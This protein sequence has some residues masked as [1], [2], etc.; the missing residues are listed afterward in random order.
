MASQ[1]RK[2]S[3]LFI[4]ITI[5]VDVIGIGIIIP[6]VPELIMSINGGTE[7]EAAE[8][9]GWLMFSFAFMQFLFAP[10]LGELS[11][12]FGRKPILIMALFG[13]GLDYIFHAYAPT[14]FWLIIG[15][16][17]A[18]F[19]GA[20][21]TVA[22]SYM[23][24]ISTPED[25]AKNFGMIGAAFGLGFIIGPVVG[26]VAAQ[27]GVQMPFFIAACLSL[28][29]MLYGILVVPESLSIENRR[30]ISIKNFN[31]INAISNLR[32]YPLITGLILAYFLIYLAGK[33][34]ENIWSFYTMLRFDWT[35]AEVGYSL[36]FVGL[37]VVVVQGGLISKVV[38]KFGQFK[39]IIIGFVCWICGLLLF[40]FATEGWMMYA[41]CIVYCMGGVA[42]PTIQ[43][44]MSNMVPGNKQGE[45]AGALTSLIS[46]TSI[47][48]PLMFTNLFSVFTRNDA[49]FEFPG[50]SFF[51]G[52]I[53]AFIAMVF[54]VKTLRSN[55][56]KESTNTL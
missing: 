48:G 35:S 39:T 26:G 49:P 14:V 27:W 40:S 21:F 51:V 46:V 17:I 3:V 56:F 6:V 15:R 29:N 16:L 52:A 23:A 44:I 20:S 43:G 50:I 13:L 7:S 36:A 9:G 24:D 22:S 38:K 11:D 34:V 30:S 4:F 8:I 25:K 33:S 10:M 53:L 2:A 47:I 55:K 18:G 37:L 19:F 45:L 12:R 42:G 1:K 54:A 5:L 41:F 31:P 28:L 32:Q